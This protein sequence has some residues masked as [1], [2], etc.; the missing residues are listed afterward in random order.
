[1]TPYD[2]ELFR[3]WL[4]QAAPMLPDD[5][6]VSEA[7]KLYDRKFKTS[8][9]QYKLGQRVWR[10]NDED[11]P[12]EFEIQE[13]D[14]HSE[15]MYLDDCGNWWCEEQLY[16][17]KRSLVKAQIKHWYSFI[18]EPYMGLKDSILER[19]VQKLEQE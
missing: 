12:Q 14:T 5:M 9:C 10:L 15:E 6:K 3:A 8:K 18:D 19:L 17:S 11:C 2:N 7:R 4:E 1:M 16:P 13:I